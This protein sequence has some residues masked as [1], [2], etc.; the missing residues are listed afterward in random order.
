MDYVILIAVFNLI[1]IG[2]LVF[3]LRSVQKDPHRYNLVAESEAYHSSKWYWP[4]KKP[5]KKGDPPDLSTVYPWKFL[6]GVVIWYFVSSIYVYALSPH[7]TGSIQFFGSGAW[8]YITVVLLLSYAFL[9][10]QF[11]PLLFKSPK[12]V[13]YSMFHICPGRPRSKV[14]EKMT[15]YVL[16]ATLVLLPFRL[17]ALCNTGYANEREIVYRPFWSIAEQRFVYDEIQDVQCEYDGDRMIH[18]Y[19]VNGNGQ[20][21]DLLGQY[22]NP[23]NQYQSVPEALR[24]LI[25]EE[26]SCRWR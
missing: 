1:W 14:L 11:I 15:R 9:L 19:L 13:C 16:I 5:H 23:T 3:K 25:P 18:C 10:S 22:T 17:F 4:P 6:A 7:E 21:F 8:F 24:E 12:A 26:L 2:F 20:R